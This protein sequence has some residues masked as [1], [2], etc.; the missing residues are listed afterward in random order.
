LR[1][2]RGAAT[3]CSA[4]SSR[5]AI[6]IFNSNLEKNVRRAINIHEGE[7]INETVLRK[8]IRAAVALSPKGKSK[9]R[10]SEF[11]TLS[12]LIA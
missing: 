9:P 5:S 12:W 2:C 3:T 7:K 11:L 8:L 4:L 10:T 6:G 1:E